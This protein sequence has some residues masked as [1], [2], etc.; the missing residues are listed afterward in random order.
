MQRIIY[1]PINT[2]KVSHNKTCVIL[3]INSIDHPI[4]IH[5][6]II[7]SHTKN[8]HTTNHAL[9]NNKSCIFIF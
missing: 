4:P 3:R 5:Y 1:Y 6:N 8:K 7:K 2:F 9:M